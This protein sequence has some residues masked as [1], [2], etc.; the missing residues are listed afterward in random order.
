MAA[1]DPQLHAALAQYAQINALL[2]E[3][4]PDADEEEYCTQFEART[5]LACEIADW[6]AASIGVGGRDDLLRLN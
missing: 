4:D 2:E 3:V 6:L 1:I 5:E